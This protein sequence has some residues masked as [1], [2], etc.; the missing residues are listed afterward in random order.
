MAGVYR[1]DVLSGR[2][3]A[4][5]TADVFE[6]PLRGVDG[7]SHALRELAGQRATVLMFVG[8]NCA[9]ARAYRERLRDLEAAYRERGVRFV[10]VNANNPYLSPSDTY[11]EMVRRAPDL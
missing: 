11:E 1:T 7:H 5:E 4:V 9:T 10:A 8:T 3:S 2:S 6:R